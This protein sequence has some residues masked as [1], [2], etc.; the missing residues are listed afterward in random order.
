MYLSEDIASTKITKNT[1]V[2]LLQNIDQGMF[3]LSPCTKTGQPLSSFLKV[4]NSGTA[5]CSPVHGVLVTSKPTT[6]PLGQ[7][8]QGKGSVYGNG[9][10]S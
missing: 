4:T 7:A 2:Y 8:G 9:G 1:T 3:V 5:V 10:Y 6:F